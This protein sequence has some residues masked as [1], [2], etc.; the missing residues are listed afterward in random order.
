MLIKNGALLAVLL[1][2]SACSGQNGAPATEKSIQEIRSEGPIRNADII[3]NPVS[4]NDPIDTV[5]VAKITFDEKAYEFG[6]VAEGEVVEH[7]FSFTNTGKAPLI[8]QGARSTCGCTVPSWPE[9]PIA[10]GETGSLHVRFD[11]KNKKSRQVKPV[12]VTANTYPATTQVYLRGFVK[13]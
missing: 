9:G 8:I 5:N 10:P 4:A 12:T 7:T 6:E 3:R 1:L 2:L 11:T 13:E